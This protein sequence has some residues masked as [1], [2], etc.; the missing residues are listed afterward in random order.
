LCKPVAVEVGASKT[1][2][3][4]PVKTIYAVKGLRSFLKQEVSELFAILKRAAKLYSKIREFDCK[5]KYLKIDNPC[6]I[7][8]SE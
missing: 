8:D 2:K 4:K 7:P 1:A 5:V 3:V 6:H